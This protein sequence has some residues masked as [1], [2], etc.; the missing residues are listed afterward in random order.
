MRLRRDLDHLESYVPGFQPVDDDWIKLNTNES[1]E[2]SPAVLDA[3]RDAL[4][5]RLRLYPDPLSSELRDRIGRRHALDPDRV[6]VGNG[7]D[8]VLNLLVRVV[9]DPGDH[10]V[11]PVPSYSLYPVLSAIRG[12]QIV[13]VPLGENF[14]LPVRQM[15]SARGKLTFVASPNNP[16]G[17]H[18]PADQIRLLAGQCNVLVVDEAYVEFADADRV[19]LLG[20]FPNLCIVRSLSKAFGLAGLRLGYGLAAPE[21]IEPLLRV[22]DSYNVGR[23]A[24]FAGVAALDDTEWAEAHWQR[25]RERREAFA[26]KIQNRFGLRVYPSNANFVLVDCG[27]H[28]AAALQR[29]LENRRILVRRF[30][31]DARTANA[32]RISIGRAAEMDAVLDALGEDLATTAAAVARESN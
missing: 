11:A 13:E 7:S 1:P 21:L 17:T 30:D 9:C 15:A 31:A 23:L 6:I 32:L 18:Y 24:Q 4:D 22:K 27:P 5:D 29:K 14:A 2:T 28:D 16:A 3:L 12:C 26:S 25:I 10:V 19:D 20:E 8:D